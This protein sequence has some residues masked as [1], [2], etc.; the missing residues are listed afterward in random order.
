MRKAKFNTFLF[1]HFSSK[2]KSALYVPS[3]SEKMLTKSVLLDASIII[4]DLEDSVALTEKEMALQMLISKLPYLRSNFDKLIYPRVNDI[5][6]KYFSSEVIKLTKKENVQFINGIHIPKIKTQEECVEINRLLLSIEKELGFKDYQIKVFPNIESASGIVFLKE[7]LICL[8]ERVE[9]V[10]F[11][12]DDFSHDI[13][14]TRTQEDFEIDFARKMFALT[15]LAFRMIPVDS[16][17]VKF[18]D[19]EGLK[20]ELLYLKK[21][22][23]KAKFAIHPNQIGVINNYLDDQ[24]EDLELSREIVKAYE[25][26]LNKGIGAINFKGQMIDMPIYK[27]AKDLISKK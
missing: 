18:N 19:S 12:A 25:E 20:K 5:N 9:I 4:P 17:Y 10:G 8:K 21:L 15:C 1:K 11:G 3:T 2:I 16:P 26:A 24:T 13:G 14:V 23:F 22:G 27:K 7:I 6:T